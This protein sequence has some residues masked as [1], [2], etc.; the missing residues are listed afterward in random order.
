MGQPREAPTMEQLFTSLPT[1]MQADARERSS[2]QR[3]TAREKNDNK[4]ACIDRKSTTTTAGI[5]EDMT[6]PEE[7]KRQDPEWPRPF[8]RI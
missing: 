2:S 4:N 5:R 3:I 6:P 7:R 1:E 8:T